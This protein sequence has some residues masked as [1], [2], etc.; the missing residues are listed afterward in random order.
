MGAEIRADEYKPGYFQKPQ[1]SDSGHNNE[2]R[3]CYAAS[4]WM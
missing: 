2:Q 3:L 4:G 1:A